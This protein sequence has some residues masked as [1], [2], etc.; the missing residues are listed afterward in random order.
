MRVGVLVHGLMPRR[1]RPSCLLAI[2]T[3]N[4]SGIDIPG[5]SAWALPSNTTRTGP[6]F[7]GIVEQLAE[8]LAEEIGVGIDDDG[9]GS[10]A[11]ISSELR[12]PARCR[13]AFLIRQACVL[14]I[15][16][17][18]LTV[19]KLAVERVMSTFLSKSLPCS[20]FVPAP[21]SRCSE[22]T[23]K[24]VSKCRRSPSSSSRRRSARRGGGGYVQLDGG[25]AANRAF[26]P[27]AIVGCVRGRSW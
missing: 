16:G 8:H 17:N 21:I 3:A 6:R 9:I 20:S 26:S 4:A 19:M 22:T 15:L 7:Q 12:R 11:P 14:L 23:R 2:A 18:F 10:G 5:P 24:L 25:I 13:C 1:Q 27:S